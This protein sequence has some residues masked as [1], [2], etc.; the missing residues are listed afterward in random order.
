MAR[1]DVTGA[2]SPDFAKSPTSYVT[3]LGLNLGG[4]RMSLQ[5]N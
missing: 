2:V 5:L 1:Y 4:F 3:L